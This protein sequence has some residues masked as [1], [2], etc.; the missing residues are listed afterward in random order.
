MSKGITYCACCYRIA[1]GDTAA[2][3]LGHDKWQYMRED[4]L[5]SIIDSYKP[6]IRLKALVSSAFSTT[7]P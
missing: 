2:E 6:E 3:A 5:E 4:N 7:R 1:Y